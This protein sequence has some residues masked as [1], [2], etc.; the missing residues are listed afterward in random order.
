[1]ESTPSLKTVMNKAILILTSLIIISCGTDD[2]NWTSVTPTFEDFKISSSCN[3]TS[4]QTQPNLINM[5]YSIEDKKEIMELYL[6]P[7]NDLNCNYSVASIRKSSVEWLHVFMNTQSGD[8]IGQLK[9]SSG[10]L[11]SKESALIIVDPL[12]DTGAPSELTAYWI[13]ENDQLKKIK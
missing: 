4:A 12:N 7:E 5:D 3:V 6:K 10:I 9:S 8:V 11:Y 13:I 1:M 2:R